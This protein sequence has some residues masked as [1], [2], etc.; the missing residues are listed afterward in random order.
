MLRTLGI[1]KPCKEETLHVT[2]G[3]LNV[4]DTEL[5]EIE[6]KFHILVDMFRDI[7][8]SRAGF[9]ITCSGVRFFDYD[10]RDLLSENFLEHLTD[11]RFVP[12]ISI[13][14]KN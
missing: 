8:N 9:M 11:I 1:G 12:H 13:Y 10:A 4:Q 14:R 2:M 6:K 7:I 5:E 3:V